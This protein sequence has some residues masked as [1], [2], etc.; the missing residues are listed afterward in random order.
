M[1]TSK[2]SVGLLTG[3]IRGLSAA[4]RNMGI[5]VTA[6]SAIS[7]AAMVSL[8]R[9]AERVNA[10]F[11]EVNSISSEVQNSQEEYGD[12]VS[13]LN[14]EFGLQ[15]SRLEVIDALYQSVSAGVQEG[16]E[17]QREFL[18]TAADLA[19]TGLVDLETS[20]DVLSTSINAYGEDTEFAEEASE[21][22]FQT[23][24]FGKVTLDELAPVMGR[25]TALGSNL[26]V[27]I[28][29]LGAS[30]AILTRTGFEARVAATG[31]RAVL[32]SLMRPSEEMKN[33]LRDM[34]FEQGGLVE[35]LTKGHEE[36]DNMA[37]EY[38][39]A[40][41][42][43]EDLTAAQEEARAVQEET[44]LSIQRARL[45][46][47]AI[48]ED[49]VDQLEDTV[50]AEMARSNTVEELEEQIE[51]YRFE[52]NQ[53]RVAEEDARIEKEELE[54]QA[55]GLIDSFSE[56][57][58]VAGDLED[59][60]GELFAENQGLVDTLVDLRSVADEN[61]IAF[62]ELFP[63]TRALQ[64]ALALVNDDGQALTEVFAAMSSEEEDAI[65]V[66]EE[67]RDEL[68]LTQDEYEEL[69]D[70]LEELEDIDMAEMADEMRGPQEAMRDATSELGEAAENLGQIF[71]EEVTDAISDFANA[72]E[73]VSDRFTSLEESTQSS[74]ARF[75][76]L[77]TSIGLVL[78][79][80]LLLGGQI[81]LIAS[82]MGVGLIQFLGVAAVLTG[83][84][85]SALNTA[86]SGGEDAN[87]LFANMQS[88]F[89]S[90]IGFL[91][92]LHRIFVYD[93]I[94]PLIYL[95]N[96]ASEVFSEIKKELE[97]VLGPS[98]DIRQSIIGFARGM[99][100][101]IIRLS[102]FL[103]DNKEVIAGVFGTIASIIFDDLL[104]AIEDGLDFAEQVGLFED[105]ERVAGNLFEALS[106]LATIITDIIE[107]DGFKMFLSGVAIL[108]GSL[109]KIVLEV[110]NIILLLVQA[111]DP[112]LTRVLNV[113]F[114]TLGFLATKFGIVFGAIAFLIEGIGKLISWIVQ[115]RI[116]FELLV[117]GLVIVAGIIFGPIVGAI[118]FLIGSVIILVNIIRW[119]VEKVV[120]SFEWLYEK[121]VGN[122]II[123]DLVNSILEWFDIDLG[124]KARNMVQS[125]VDGMLDKISAVKDAA[126]SVVGAVKDYLGF[127]SP[128]E[129]GPGSE[130]GGPYGWGEAGMDDYEAAIRDSKPNVEKASSEVAEASVPNT[131]DV[132]YEPPEDVDSE[133]EHGDGA[134]SGSSMGGTEVTVEEG[135][136]K[137]GP[138]H[139]LADD[140]V[141]EKVDE[142]VDESMEQLVEDLRAKGIGGE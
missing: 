34:A 68:D 126:K 131:E 118:A 54:E 7:G 18:E 120:G 25:I 113:V 43:I 129:E 90:L 28:Q 112:E 27:E 56:E 74:I 69:K 82:A 45:A 66:L 40:T 5:A 119:V 71:N 141:V 97:E 41:S 14:T 88:T 89:D 137:V 79:P 65:D 80:L 101:A 116:A 78:G 33:L 75:A 100:R 142:E 52:V 99:G 24:Q 93:L 76:V 70:E 8:S 9:R 12:L 125:F 29:E 104:P 55:Q 95:G 23:V 39:D 60:I 42:A 37:Q 48:E 77:A 26:G 20:V 47:Q 16:S 139:G 117:A 84:F 86:V 136:I 59:G 72:I 103:K 51:N 121:L 30:M 19:V 83:V 81:A 35:E 11:R 87:D 38:R 108:M 128:T 61:N 123:P 91:S 63:R 107:T 21:A 114:L 140:E 110:V 10:A 122:S 57:L 98:E 133:Y 4:M 49:R 105:L 134:G 127:S 109:F 67:N 58:E 96:A 2:E 17:A 44:S 132:E 3:S 15:A 115:T 85:A 102:D 62:D 32:R 22:L 36:L 64:A 94:P 13:E 124:Q 92:F 31:V 46:I 53:A 135:A 6:A 73:R 50:A 130:D 1:R 106:T 111:L 138:F